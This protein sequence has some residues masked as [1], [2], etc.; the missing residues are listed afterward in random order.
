M[1]G[2]TKYWP[3]VFWF[4]SWSLFDTSVYRTCVKS[5]LGVPPIRL[6][7]VLVT[8]PEES[9]DWINLTASLFVQL[10]LFQAFSKY[11]KVFHTYHPHWISP[12]Q[13]TEKF[14][15]FSLTPKL[16]Y[17]CCHHLGSEPLLFFARVVLTRCSTCSIFLRSARLLA[18]NIITV[19]T[20]Q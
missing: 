14:S 5:H 12:S 18:F 19:F 11:W 7:F 6:G 20:G 2:I 10:P 17:D 15:S 3:Q 8:P 16:K 4:L 9:W 13:L 1:S